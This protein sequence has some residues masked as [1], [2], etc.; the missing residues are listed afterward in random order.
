MRLRWKEDYC[1]AAETGGREDSFSGTWRPVMGGGTGTWHKGDVWQTQI[2]LYSSSSCVST[3][4][5]AIYC[6][7][8]GTPASD[9]EL[10]TLTKKWIIKGRRYQN[11]ASPALIQTVV[12][13]VHKCLHV[14]AG[15]RKKKKHEVVSLLKS[16][17]FPFFLYLL[18][19][20]TSFSVN[21]KTWRLKLSNWGH[22]SLMFLC[23]V[24]VVFTTYTD[25]ILWGHFGEDCT[26]KFA[27][28]C[29]HTMTVKFL[30]YILF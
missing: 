8:E 1:K 18:V 12:H 7:F 11:R 21:E 19:G 6:T 25:C 27:V 4:V 13:W 26:L 30:Y 29:A 9:N 23:T 28:Q 2:T 15:K 20:L 17:M 24:S 3:L 22:C 14:G 16:S 5:R 10:R